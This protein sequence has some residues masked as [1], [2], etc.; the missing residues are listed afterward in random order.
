MDTSQIADDAGRAANNPTIAEFLEARIGED[1]ARARKVLATVEPDEWENPTSWGNFYPEDIAFWD[2]HTPTRA[3]SECAAKRAIMAAA[4]RLEDMR[5]DGN[6]WNMEYPDDS[7][8]APLASV[9]SDHPDYQQEWA[10]R[11]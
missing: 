4:E 1:E 3:L 8:L 6:L 11:G 5:I 10:P 9:Y 2:T 7:L